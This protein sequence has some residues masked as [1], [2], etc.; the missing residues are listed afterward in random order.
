MLLRPGSPRLCRRAPLAAMLAVAACSASPTESPFTPGGSAAGDAGGSDAGTQDGGSKDADAG[1]PDAPADACAP[2]CSTDHKFVLGCGDKVLE[3]C[4]NDEM[5]AGGACKPACEAARET[6]S[7]VGC[8]YYPVMMQGILG[9]RNGCFAVFVANPWAIAAH[10]TVSY[11]SAT[12]DPSAFGYLPKGGGMTLSYEPLDAA[13]GIPPGQVAI[14]FLHGAP[15]PNPDAAVECPSEVHAASSDTKVQVLGTGLGWAYHVQTDVPVVAY[16]MLPYGGGSAAVTGASLLLPSS[17]WHTNYV[18]VNAY[19]RGEQTNTRP[20]LNIVAA[21]DGTEVTM[22]PR[23]AVEGGNGVPK[24]A[25]NAVMKLTLAAGQHAQITQDDELTGSPIDSTKPV[26]LM[27][28]HECM[29]VPP[30]ADYCD[31]A[32]QQIPPVRALGHV[33]AAVS[34]RP[35]SN[36]AEHPP[37]RILGAVP[38]TKLSFD[39][40]AIHAPQTI[41]LGDIVELVTA[42]PFVVRS[43]DK[44]HPFLVATYMTG[45][46]TVQKGYGDPDFVRIVPVSQYLSRYVFF[47]DPSYP[48]TNLVVVR[49]KGKSGFADVTLDCAGVLD[50]WEPVGTGGEVEMTRADLVRHDFQPQGKCNNGRH[51]MKSD[52]P[53]G[54]WVWGWGSPETQTFTDNVSYGYPAGENVIQI[55]NA[56]VPPVPK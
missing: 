56:F 27:A 48:E 43:Q 12:L 31:H 39:P 52:E 28:G 37:W 42:E 50:G 14:L 22:V 18:A 3:V 32:E 44:D 5:C 46:S 51:E 30:T 17:A 41:G 15:T 16:Q 40:P 47:T 10:V 9:S 2:R 1:S 33:H 7:S 20:S 25:A 35:R 6:Q 38:G 24:T 45:S 55:N 13:K 29:N 8:D 26:A 53:F 36:A 54:L 21:E 11:R 49:A 34:H 4:G 23:A 19:R